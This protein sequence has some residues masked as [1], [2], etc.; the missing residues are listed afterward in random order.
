MALNFQNKDRSNLDN[1]LWSAKVVPFQIQLQQLKDVRTRQQTRIQ[2]AAIPDTINRC[3]EFSP[4]VGQNL[5][6]LLSKESTWC[7]SNVQSII[8]IM[9]CSKCRQNLD[10]VRLLFCDRYGISSPYSDHSERSK[11]QREC[12]NTKSPIEVKSQDSHAIPISNT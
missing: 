2:C 6:N 12:T 9:L 4:F 11:N 10:Y 5:D 8:S 3:K 7:I 1:K